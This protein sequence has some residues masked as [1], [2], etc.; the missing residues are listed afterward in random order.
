MGI[1]GP[2][3]ETLK[4]ESIKTLKAREPIEMHSVETQ[5]CNSSAIA[6]LWSFLLVCHSYHQLLLSSVVFQAWFTRYFSPS[7]KSQPCFFAY[8]DKGSARGFALVLILGFV[9]KFFVFFMFWVATIL[10]LQ[11]HCVGLLHHCRQV[12]SGSSYMIY[13]LWNATVGSQVA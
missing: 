3:E 13:L 7:S 8:L 10:S 4:K 5:L 2:Q 1:F 9:L 12:A 11:L 6:S